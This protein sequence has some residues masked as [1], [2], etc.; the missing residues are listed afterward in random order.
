MGKGFAALGNFRCVDCRLVDM[1]EVPE[2]AT[3]QMRGAGTPSRRTTGAL[4]RDSGR[5]EGGPRRGSGSASER[6]GER[7][8]RPPQRER[9]I[10]RLNRE[11]VPML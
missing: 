8:A 2:E 9:T 1:T 11:R 6:G 3:E 5:R 4:R 10:Q 7:G